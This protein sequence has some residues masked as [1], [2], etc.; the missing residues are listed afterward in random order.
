M[1]G[2][3]G[4]PDFALPTPDEDFGIGWLWEPGAHHEDA[5]FDRN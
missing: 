3:G 5:R 2:D 1:D 4:L